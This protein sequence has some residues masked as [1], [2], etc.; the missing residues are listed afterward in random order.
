[1]SELSNLKV[2]NTDQ[3]QAFDTEYVDDI[4]WTIVEN[5][6][7]RDFPDGS[8]KF[9]DMGG[10]NGIFAD[11]ILK[12]YPH[13]TGVVYD[14]SETLIAKNK[15]DSRKIL[16][17]DSLENISQY[18][19]CAKADLVFL[20]W[21]LHHLVSSSRKKTLHNITNTLTKASGMLSDKGRISVFENMYDGLLFDGLPSRLIFMLTSSKALAPLVR[22]LGANTAGC[23]VCML[24][25]RT[26]NHMF[27]LA[28]LQVF[29]YTDDHPWP[30]S[31]L[32]R[33]LLHIGRLRV[34]HYWA[35]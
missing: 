16:I 19:E 23:G 29:D 7:N 30:V 33:T 6:I 1:M 34:G 18:D 13:S 5:L 2:L 21:V 12:H 31:L 4:R 25:H 8:F 20:N 10:G 15:P 3:V 11:R 22:K 35:K 27:V 28:G 26:W 32:R 17:C 14:L 9:I 24:S